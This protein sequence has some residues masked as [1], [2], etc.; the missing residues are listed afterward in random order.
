MVMTKI[1]RR[2]GADTMTRNFEIERL[3]GCGIT[4]KVINTGAL[5]TTFSDFARAAGYPEAI[6]PKCKDIEGQV[7]NVLAKGKH[8]CHGCVIYVIENSYGNCYLIEDFGL[9]ITEPEEVGKIV[10]DEILVAY[11]RGY[12]K[13]KEEA[14][15]ELRRVMSEWL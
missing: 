13:G 3:E 9:T 5:Y 6:N 4:A 15:A 14:M 11:E 2:I 10:V 7:V 12:A 1:K 8:D